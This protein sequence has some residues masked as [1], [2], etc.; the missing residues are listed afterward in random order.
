MS[1]KKA[2]TQFLSVVDTIKLK[3]FLESLNGLPWQ[4][5]RGLLKTSNTTRD[6]IEQYLC[7]RDEKNSDL[8][9]PPDPDDKQFYINV[10]F[11]N[12][13]IDYYDPIWNF[14]VFWNGPP[15]KHIKVYS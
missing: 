14:Y 8:I 9:N 13:T 7:A 12:F 1:S 11:Q 3:T 15:Q 5:L 2:A 4:T 6:D 10:K